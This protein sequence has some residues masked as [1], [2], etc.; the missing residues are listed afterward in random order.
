MDLTTSTGLTHLVPLL[1]PPPLSLT[2]GQLPVN[3]GSNDA[4]LAYHPRV[5][6]L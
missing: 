2:N 5:Q 4:L 6:R 1:Y 3:E